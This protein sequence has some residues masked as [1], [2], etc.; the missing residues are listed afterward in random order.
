MFLPL[1]FIPHFLMIYSECRVKSWEDK[2][3]SCL[4]PLPVRNLSVSTYFFSQSTK[5]HIKTIWCVTPIS[6]KINHFISV[7][8]DFYFLPVF[9]ACFHKAFALKTR[10]GQVHSNCTAFLN[11]LLIHECTPL[12]GSIVREKMSKI[13]SCLYKESPE[14]GL[15]YLEQISICFQAQFRVT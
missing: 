13:F 2:I 5:S 8:L 12:I 10:M 7:T 15:L 1:I 14:L 4:T 11:S 9:N 6:F 3:H